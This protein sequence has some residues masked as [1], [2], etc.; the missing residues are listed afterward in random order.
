VFNEISKSATT[1]ANL[2]V[3]VKDFYKSNQFI[4]FVYERFDDVRLVGTPPQSIG[5][6]GGDTDNWEWPRQTGDFSVFRV[7]SSTSN[8]PAKY[9]VENVP[10][11]PKKF[12]PISIK[13][14]KNGDF[15]MVY[16]YP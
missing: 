5:K 2:E 13:G 9:S 3:V 11:K 14:V 16:G 15:A 4:L 8:Q 10:Y 6:F 12:L 7:Y 1:S